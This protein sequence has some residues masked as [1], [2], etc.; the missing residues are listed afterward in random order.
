MCYCCGLSGF[1]MWLQYLVFL[2]CGKWVRCSAVGPVVWPVQPQWVAWCSPKACNTGTQMEMMPLWYPSIYHWAE[3]SVRGNIFCSNEMEFTK[4]WS[5]VNSCSFSVLVDGWADRAKSKPEFL[6]MQTVP[7][8]RSCLLPP[9]SLTSYLL[10][11]HSNGGSTSFH[12][13][14]LID[15]VEPWEPGVWF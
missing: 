7:S 12:K 5:L 14:P 13:L 2:K 8:C 4:D 9:S 3:A 10:P 15:T 11:D 1:H 6:W